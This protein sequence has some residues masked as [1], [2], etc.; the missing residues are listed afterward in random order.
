MLKLIA[1]C[2]L[3]VCLLTYELFSD[4]HRHLWMLFNSQTSKNRWIKYHYLNFSF[5]LYFGCGCFLLRDTRRRPH[6]PLCFVPRLPPFQVKPSWG[7]RDCTRSCTNC[8][9]TSRW[10][11]KSPFWWARCRAC[12]RYASRS[13]P[14]CSALPAAAEQPPRE[15]RYHPAFIMRGGR[16]VLGEAVTA[17][18]GV[19]VTICSDSLREIFLTCISSHPPKKLIFAI[20]FF[21]FFFCYW[22]E[23]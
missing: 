12:T 4:L 15:S 19:D 14:L 9:M 21:S 11:R 3:S 8:N 1:A 16:G 23:Y 5:P 10:W 22:L 17:G 20:I 18:R 7:L 2:D 6:Q 13:A